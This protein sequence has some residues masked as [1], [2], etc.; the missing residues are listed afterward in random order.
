MSRSPTLRRAAD[1]ARISDDPGNDAKGVARQ[2]EDSRARIDRD[3]DWDYVGS[4]VDND[5]SAA[6]GKR[7]PRFEA[8]ME[9]VRR[10]EVQVIV[11][12][13]TGRL[14]RNRRERMET[15]ELLAKHGVRIVCTKGPDLDFST[16]AGRMVAGILGEVDTH[17][18]EQL[19]TRVSDSHLQAAKEGRPIGGR[20]YGYRPDPHAPKHHKRRIV[21]P[22]EAAVIREAADRV[23]RGDSVYSVAQD[24]NE[25]GVPTLHAKRSK[26]GGLWSVAVLRDILA[27]PA[28]AGRSMLLGVD[29]GE[30]EWEPI[31]DYADHLKIV[32]LF[33]GRSMPEGWTNRHVHLLSG[34]ALC[35]KC[36]VQ[37][38]RIAVNCRQGA[39]PT[40][41]GYQPWPKSRGYVCPDKARGGCRGLRHAADFVDDYVQGVVLDMLAE[42]GTIEQLTA[43]GAPDADEVLAV[44]REIEATKAR[45]VA[46]GVELAK[47]E[48]SEVRRIMIEAEAAELEAEMERLRKRE[49]SLSRSTAAESLI[50]VEDIA[51]HWRDGMTL[52]QRRGVIAALVEI[53]LL[54]IGRGKRGTSDQIQIRRRKLG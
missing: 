6:K 5:L 28:I 36:L 13:M 43:A 46:L 19:A 53:T 48:T 37:G 27:N 7:R 49:A 16:P 24:L 10:G 23:L 47:R 25:R 2:T 11:I 44:A 8:L 40:P 51:E 42:P 18:I 30:A 12:Y 32:G 20:C 26:N 52:S 50:G 38:R 29:H 41:S 14:V 15:Y 21:V 17:E 45:A 35:G 33:S 54:P 4:F 34:I 31:I 3:P 9:A 39:K 22:E 1:Y